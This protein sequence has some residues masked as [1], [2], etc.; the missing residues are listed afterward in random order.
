M[1]S[2]SFSYLFYV[3]HGERADDKKAKETSR[4]KVPCDCPLSL[5]GHNMCKDAGKVI[6]E[7]IRDTIGHTGPVTMISSPF[8]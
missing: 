1:E 4:I 8:I 6:N 7:Y 2:E 5:N 3:R